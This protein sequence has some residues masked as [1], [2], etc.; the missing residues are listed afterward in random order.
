MGP[1]PRAFGDQ[2]PGLDRPPDRGR[3]LRLLLDAYGLHDRAGFLD[4]VAARI[5]YNRDIMT[6]RAAA[7]D[8]AYQ[9]LVD[10]GHVAGMDE[11]LDFLAQHGPRLQSQLS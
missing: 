7:G 10:Q 2:L 1:P 11:A 9:S 4:Q 8:Q 3:R 6:S 5:A